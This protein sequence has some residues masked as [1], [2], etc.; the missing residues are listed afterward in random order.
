M[1][2]SRGKSYTGVLLVAVAMGLA[3]WVSWP[4]VKF[5]SSA[6]PYRSDA[7]HIYFPFA[8][9]HAGFSYASLAFAH[10]V[11]VLLSFVGTMIAG[12]GLARA[13][14]ASRGGAVCAGIVLTLFPQRLN[15]L[16]GGEAVGFAFFL[17]PMA[18]WGLEKNWQTGRIGW[19]CTAAVSLMMM[20]IQN[21]PYLFFFCLLLPFWLLWKLLHEKAMKLPERTGAR[22]L[23]IVSAVSWQA[24]LAAGL[25][26]VTYHFQRVRMRAVPPV[27]PTFIGLLIFFSLAVLGV[28]LLM[29]V[30]LRW[31]GVGEEPFRRRWLSWPWASFWLLFAYFAADYVNAPRFG[32]RLLLGSLLLFG[33]CHLAFLLRAIQKEK[34]SAGAVHLPWGRVVKLWPAAVGLVIAMIYPLYL[35]VAF[36]AWRIVTE[37]RAAVRATPF[38]VPW[39]KLFIRSP[40]GGAYV[41]W[42]FIGLMLTATAAILAWRKLPEL[43]PHFPAGT[44]LSPRGAGERATGREESPASEIGPRLTISLVLTGLGMVLACGAL[45]GSVFPLH[46]VILWFAPFLRN[47]GSTAKYLLLAATGGA[48]AVALL[49]TFLER[50]IPSGFVRGWLSPAVA[51]LLIL[52]WGLVWRDGVRVLPRQG[53]LYDMVSKEGEGGRLLELP[54]WPGDTAFY[55]PYQYA[56]MPTATLAA[57][58]CSPMVTVNYRENIAD[59]LYPLNFGILTRKEFELLKNLNVRFIN[60][61]QELFPRKVSSLPATS[62]LKNLVLNPNLE[63][64]AKE[65]GAHLFRLA[66]KAYI[67][68]LGDA[69]EESS[70]F[71]YVPYDLL[72]HRVGAERYDYGAIRKKAWSSKGGEGLLFFGPFLMLPPGEYVAVFRVKVEGP[73]DVSQVG[74]LDVATGEGTE[75]ATRQPLNPQDW[76]EPHGYRFVEI[77]FRVTRPHPVETRCFLAG[78]K[79]ATVSLDF[80]LIER[81]NQGQNIRLEAENFFST[82]GCVLKEAKATEGICL[83]VSGLPPRGQPLLEETFVFLAAG[84]YEICCSARGESGK[85]ATLRMRRVAATPHYRR[86]DVSGGKGDGEGD[87]AVSKGVL[88]LATGG[89]HAV[90]LWPAGKRLNAVDYIFLALVPPGNLTPL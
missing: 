81:K 29:D 42:V 3:T 41:G 44:V 38:S 60:F 19:G 88:N 72:Q 1:A 25:F 21:S 11:L 84:R 4:L 47:I 90:S 55:S 64:V 5:L 56:T 9:A 46:N 20:G 63:L 12:Y 7:P 75:F 17:F 67:P 76:P 78:E 73:R 16:F 10:N 48:V 31:L 87:F 59:P 8:L 45:L 61:H 69:M 62:S 51:V 26:A 83:G 23:R 65:G 77:P 79:T 33:V 39:Q 52:D 85:M 6:M 86:F 30:V 32:S 71:Y 89:V 50:R 37:G 24:M 82:V 57:M 22:R 28:V 66:R 58:A 34:L 70:L 43:R 53:P 40:E 49:L 13:F 15:S 18:W 35:K 27:S 36:L 68:C 2:D 80:V 14:G 54:I 74:Y